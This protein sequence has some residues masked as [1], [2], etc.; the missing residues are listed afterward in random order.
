MLAAQAP[1]LLALRNG[2]S[3]LLPVNSKALSSTHRQLNDQCHHTAASTTLDQFQHCAA[4]PQRAVGVFDSGVG[5]LSVLKTLMAEMPHERFVYVADSLNAPY[6]E[7]GDAFVSQRTQAITDYL[8]SQHHIKAIVV[9]CNTATAAAV[10]EIRTRYP[11][12]PMVGIEP[13][14]KPAASTTT[15]GFV[16]VMATRGTLGS[17]K[18]RK[19]LSSFAQSTEFITQ[20]CDGLAYAIEQSTS[21][22]TFDCHAQVEELCRLYTDAMGRSFGKGAGQIDTLVLG[23]THYVF[24]LP[25]LGALVGNEVTILET[26]L[27]VAKQTKRLLATS[28]LLVPDSGADLPR[29]DGLVQLYT[30]GELP[31]LQGA[32][33]RWLRL[34][35]QLCSSVQIP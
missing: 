2:K 21:Q 6:G 10:H 11:T 14:L 7:K 13:A 17:T 8:L 29:S 31:M 25:I 1:T 9:A 5:G 20:S 15:T 30:T 19:L 33:K 35:E 27:P 22:D 23:C 12:L 32:V 18:F 3:V 34:P 24:A 28:G 4:M 26:G 16:G